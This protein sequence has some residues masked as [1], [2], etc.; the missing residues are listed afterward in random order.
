MIRVYVKEYIGEFKNEEEADEYFQRN[1]YAFDEFIQ[2]VIE[3][4]EEL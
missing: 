3:E 1:H 2:P 4:E